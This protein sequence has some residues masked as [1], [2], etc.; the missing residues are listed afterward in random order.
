MCDSGLLTLQRHAV[1][2]E[3]I[4]ALPLPYQHFVHLLPDNLSAPSFSD[5]VEKF[6]ALALT[7]LL[8]AMFTARFAATKGRKASTASQRDQTS[9][10]LLLTSQAMHLIP[11]ELEEYPLYKDAGP[12][13]NEEVGSL[14]LNALC[15]AGHLVA[16]SNDEIEQI[17][18][19]EGGIKSILSRVGCKPVPDVTVACMSTERSSEY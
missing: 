9:W 7:R 17:R 19:Q 14:S 2:T 18:K 4:H 15:F 3:I 1:N 6:L 16:K 10:N 8:D 13:G 12:A 11:R 5:D